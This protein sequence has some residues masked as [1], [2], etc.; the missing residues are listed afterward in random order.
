MFIFWLISFSVFVTSIVKN[1]DTIKNVVEKIA[2]KVDTEGND[3]HIHI[4]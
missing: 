3:F 4:N 1:H 2:D